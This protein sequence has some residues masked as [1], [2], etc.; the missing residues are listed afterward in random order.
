MKAA[1]FPL[2]LLFLLLQGSPGQEVVR[3]Q[4]EAPSLESLVNVSFQADIRIFTVMAALNAAGFDYESPG[5]E[6]SPVRASVRRD[7]ES[8]NPELRAELREFYETARAELPE[9]EE[10]IVYTSL[11]LLLSAP[12]DFKVTF[13][14]EDLPGET[15]RIKGFEGLVQRFY[16]EANIPALW[17]RYQS[18]YAAELASYRPVL[19]ELI[20]EALQYFRIPPR[21]VLDGQIILIADLLNT[22]GVV[23]ARHVNR[24][25]YIVAGPAEDP[26]QNR[27]QLQHAY[28]HFLL[29]PLVEKHGAALLRHQHLLDLA[30]FQP[31]IKPEYQNQFLLVVTESLIE[32]IR[33]RIY[34]PEDLDREVLQLFRQGLIFVPT[35]LRGLEAYERD[36]FFSLPSYLEVLFQ[37]IDDSQIREDERLVAALETRIRQ[38]RHEAAAQRRREDEER[39]MRA[40]LEDLLAEAGRLLSEGEDEA[41]EERL[42][43]LLETD[44]GNASALFY[45]AQIASRRQDHRRALELYSQ[46]GD[47]PSAPAA[48]RGWSFVRMGRILA[49]QGEFDKARELFTLVLSLPGDL[50]G[51]FEEATALLGQLPAREP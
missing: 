3:S 32:S 48:V 17:Q 18:S 51:A 49:S 20:R 25:Y 44:P 35:F 26:G 12:P 19:Q 6:W 45:R 7:L 9:A 15:E 43:E 41:A 46:V 8:L 4:G 16:R 27:L 30:Q 37:E 50:Q 2:P 22:H 33:L 10:H 14:E 11:A 29:D 5:K 31:R 34:P 13:P 47:S 40:R 24:V 39:A 38:E 23:N 36:D 28:L 21:I 42:R 1:A